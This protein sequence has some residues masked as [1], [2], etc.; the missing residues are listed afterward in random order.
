MDDMPSHL[1]LWPSSLAT[2]NR[3]P[4][5]AQTSPKAGAGLPQGWRQPAAK[6]M[7]SAA[8]AVGQAASL[9]ASKARES[10]S[11]GEGPAPPTPPPEGTP[12]GSQGD[13]LLRHT[14]TVP[15]CMSFPS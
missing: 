8:S 3:V 11:A 5:S 2:I 1:L 7:R 9:G 14:D 10:V 4:S 12:A 15:V 6:A 13:L